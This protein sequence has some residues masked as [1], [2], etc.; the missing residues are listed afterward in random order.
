[1]LE[2]QWNNRKQKQFSKSKRQNSIR[3]KRAE[4][5]NSKRAKRAKRAKGQ[6]GKRAKRAKRAKAQTNIF[7]EL[8][9]LLVLQVGLSNQVRV[10]YTPCKV[11]LVLPDYS[12]T[13]LAHLVGRLTFTVA[14]IIAICTPASASF[15]FPDYGRHLCRLVAAFPPA[16][17]FTPRLHAWPCRALIS[18][19]LAKFCIPNHFLERLQRPDLGSYD[20]GKFS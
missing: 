1:M 4:R 12:P 14:K 20:N 8:H 3:A 13:C 6:K 9:Q 5:Q 11:L 17:R 2:V 18:H 16:P 10:A 19:N 15:R 7:P